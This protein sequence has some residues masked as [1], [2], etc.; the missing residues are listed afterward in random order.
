MVI[1]S[2]GGSSDDKSRDDYL[3]FARTMGASPTGD[4]LVAVSRLSGLPLLI[5][6][7]ADKPASD[8][9]VNTIGAT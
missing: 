9:I 5:G 4:S 6:W 7:V 8:A 2:F 1:H 3:S